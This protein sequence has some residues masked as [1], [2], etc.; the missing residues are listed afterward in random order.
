MAIR[1]FDQ[2]A[3][4][5]SSPTRESLDLRASSLT[6]QTVGTFSTDTISVEGS[7]DGENWHA[8]EVENLADGTTAASI[9]AEGLFRASLKSITFWRL[10]KTGVADTITVLVH[11][12]QD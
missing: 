7:L 9:G 1:L 3:D 2:K 8:L 6:V 10:T 12:D 11:E 5:G 4:A